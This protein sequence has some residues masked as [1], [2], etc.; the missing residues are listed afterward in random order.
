MRILAIGAHP[1]DIEIGCGGTLAKMAQQGFHIEVIVATNGEAGARNI[2]KEELSQIREKEALHSA[3]ILGVKKVH[4][5]GLTD[6]LVQFNS[7]DK[8]KMISLIRRIRPDIIFTH[9]EQDY[10]PDHRIISDLTNSAVIGSAGPW[11]QDSSGEP[12]NVNAVYGYEVWHPLNKHQCV[13]DITK[14]LRIKLKAL[15][16]H[17]SQL[18]SIDYCKIVE[19]L[20]TYRGATSGHDYAEVFDVRRSSI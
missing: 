14:T 18:A 5:L 12:H 15:S 9:S 8:I 2:A 20:A 13:E 11:Y 16:A 17:K 6:G 10:F 19:G 7:E 3:K 4:F 1:D